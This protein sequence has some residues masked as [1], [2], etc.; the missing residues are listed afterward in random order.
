[1]RSLVFGNTMDIT[2][3]ITMQNLETRKMVADVWPACK[4]SGVVVI[5]VVYIK[6]RFQQGRRAIDPW[7]QDDCLAL[8]CCAALSCM[9]HVSSLEQRS[10]FRQSLVTA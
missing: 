3:T 9:L 10:A 2:I 8:P 4:L 7:L 6:R 1:M 5:Y